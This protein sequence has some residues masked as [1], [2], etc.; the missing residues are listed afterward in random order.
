MNDIDL[1]DVTREQAA[2]AIKGA[3]DTVKI[4]AYYKPNG[5]Y[6]VSTYSLSLCFIALIFEVASYFLSLMAQ[7]VHMWG[8]A[9]GEN[10]HFLYVCCFCT[11]FCM[12]CCSVFLQSANVS[13]VC[14]VNNL[15]QITFVVH[16][17]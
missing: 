4:T 12:F 11:H 15:T 13:S 8:L 17:S 10:V 6:S 7:T 5:T 14:L 2:A 16:E 1:C 9:T 3:G